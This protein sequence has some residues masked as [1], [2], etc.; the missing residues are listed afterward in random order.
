M[1]S[2]M[3]FI[4]PNGIF[5]QPDALLKIA[6]ANRD[7]RME[8]DASGNMQAEIFKPKSDPQVIKIDQNT[9][10]TGEDVLKGLEITIHDFL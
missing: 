2:E 6:S 10:L 1:R 9:V 5:L 7:L 4:V 3:K 8:Q